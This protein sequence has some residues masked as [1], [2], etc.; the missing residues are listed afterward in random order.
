MSTKLLRKVQLRRAEELDVLNIMRPLYATRSGDRWVYGGD[1]PRE[2]EAHPIRAHLGEIMQDILVL[3][4]SDVSYYT[5]TDRIIEHVR[6][7]AK[8][9]DNSEALALNFVETVSS[10]E[11][12]RE[13]LFPSMKAQFL[14]ILDASQP[15][16][17]YANIGFLQLAV[18]VEGEADMYVRSEELGEH[19]LEPG[20]PM[21]WPTQQPRTPLRH[22]GF[23][24]GIVQRGTD[25][26]PWRLRVYVTP[27]SY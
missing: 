27:D 4:N 3:L 2:D 17:P 5:I 13:A 26:L 22:I 16:Q 19:S 23:I 24:L 20:S 18:V 10:L 1:D 9:G 21:Y 6:S 25:N 15:Q 14:G 12:I 11:D 8:E 7:R